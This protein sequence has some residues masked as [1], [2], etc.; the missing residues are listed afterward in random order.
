MINDRTNFAW[1]AFD[2]ILPNKKYRLDC[3]HIARIILEQQ[4]VVL[5]AILEPFFYDLVVTMV[6]TFI[7]KCPFPC[8]ATFQLSERNNF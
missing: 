1:H 8:L 2:E 7:L 5:E 6:F 4:I 3:P